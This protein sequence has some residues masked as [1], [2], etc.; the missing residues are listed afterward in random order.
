MPDSFTYVR[1]RER[2][3]RHKDPTAPETSLR[4]Y[5]FRKYVA[6]EPEEDPAG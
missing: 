6:N 4:D 2:L 5:L 3:R 1:L